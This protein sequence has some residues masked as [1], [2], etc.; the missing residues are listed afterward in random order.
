MF[1][2]E[3]RILRSIKYLSELARPMRKNLELVLILTANWLVEG[4]G[5]SKREAEEDAAQ[6]A[7]DFYKTVVTQKRG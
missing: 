3:D 2:Q 6:K 5:K 1:N 4:E 7:L